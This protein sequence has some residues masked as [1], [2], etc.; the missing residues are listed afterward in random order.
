KRRVDRIRRIDQQQRVAVRWRMDRRFGADIVARA[1]LVLDD[2]LLAQPF[3]QPLRHDARRDVRAPAGSVGNDPTYPP[4]RGLGR[5]G[6]ADPTPRKDGET[7]GETAGKIYSWDHGDAC[8]LSPVF[9]ANEPAVAVPFA[10]LRAKVRGIEALAQGRRAIA[11]I[12]EVARFAARDSHHCLT[13]HQSTK[14]AE[15][16]TAPLRRSLTILLRRFLT[17]PS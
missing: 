15:T 6:R 11:F 12:P 9:V 4:C 5:R 8:L 17:I 3:R 10:T 16:C 14:L 1:R 7:R 2:K 13:M